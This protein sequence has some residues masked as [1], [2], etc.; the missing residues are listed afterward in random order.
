MDRANVRKFLRELPIAIALVMAC[1]ASLVAVSAP[2]A[3]R[4]NSEQ[5]P[6]VIAMME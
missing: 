4:L 5:V 3:D 1:A 6:H 2:Y